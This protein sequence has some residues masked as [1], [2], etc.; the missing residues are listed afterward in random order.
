[1]KS[2]GTALLA[3]LAAVAVI[4][5]ISVGSY[6]LGIFGNH[7]QANYQKRVVTSQVQQQVRTAAFAQTAYEQFFDLCASVQTD[8]VTLDASLTQE[9]TAS[10][11]DKSRLET[12][13]VGLLA[14]RADSINTYNAQAR[15]YT[16]GQFRDSNLPFRLPVGPYTKGHHTRCGS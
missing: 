5:G 8:E 12:N 9:K 4:A 1:M 15:E 14:A 3:L 6:Y 2:L 10:P 13:I 11:D 7:V 16:H